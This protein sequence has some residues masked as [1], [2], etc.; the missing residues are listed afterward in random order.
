MEG[1]KMILSLAWRNVWRNRKRSVIILA[2]ISFGLWGGILSGAIMMGMGESMVNTAIDRD[3]SH[4]QIHDPAFLKEKE[5]FNDLPYS[6]EMY[7]KIK[8]INGVESISARTLITGM[9][10][11][12]ASSFGVKIYG[13]DP[14]QSQKVTSISNNLI[15]GI[16]FEPN[17]KNQ[18]I[19]GK[20]LAKRLNVKIRSKVVLSFQGLKGEIVY[21]AC[22]IV[23]IFKTESSIFDETNL[24]VKQ[25]DLFRSLDSDPIF[26]EIAI[27]CVDSRQVELVAQELKTFIKNLDIQTWNEL[28]PELAFLSTTMKS[29]TLLFVV[30]ILLALVFGI[31]NTMLMAVMERTREIGILLAVGMKKI[32]IFIMILLET[33]ML[34]I[35]GGTV[36]IFI[37]GAT[38]AYLAVDGIDLTA[39]AA[40]MESFGVSTLLYP[41]LPIGMY[42]VLTLL[43]ILAAVI[44]A[45]YPA[46]KAIRLQPAEAVRI[47]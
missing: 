6:S 14:Q 45:V 10:S 44:A 4:I 17:R 35:S 3:L 21:I 18:I 22:R 23:G 27:R 40:S 25:A 36:G 38:V 9:A 46:L 41:F 26:H 37:G 16:Y 29:F 43:V 30:I 12:P 39:I 20:K 5:I 7:S 19:I 32:K 15:E 8:S 1:I 11:S 2:A 33:V 28:A 31:T 34:S 42:F 47:Y 24:F 13:I